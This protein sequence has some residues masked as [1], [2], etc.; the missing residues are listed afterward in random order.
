MGARTVS[1]FLDH[2]GSRGS[3]SLRGN[4]KADRS[5]R[6]GRRAFGAAAADL[7]PLVGD[8]RCLR[9]VGWF[10]CF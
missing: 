10:R 7:T 1:G 3:L 4:P 5:P 2:A 9:C 8:G 6:R